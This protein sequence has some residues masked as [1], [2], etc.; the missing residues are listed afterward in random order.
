MSFAWEWILVRLTRLRQEML[1][2]RTL[3]FFERFLDDRMFDG[4]LD[5]ND[6]WR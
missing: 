5:V 4:I 6:E 1:D 3:D 2:E